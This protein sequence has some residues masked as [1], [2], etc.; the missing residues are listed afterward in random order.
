R[1]SKLLQQIA[2]FGLETNELDVA[3]KWI[4]AADSYANGLDP[5]IRH[6]FAEFAY[7]RSEQA[8]LIGE[9][10]QYLQQAIKICDEL[11]KNSRNSSPHPFHTILKCNLYNIEL[12]LEGNDDATV[13]RS[14]KEFDRRLAIAKQI[15]PYQDFILSAEAKFNQLFDNKPAALELME[16]AH[17]VNPSSPFIVSRL[18]ALLRETKQFDKIGRIIEK[19]LKNLPGDRELN[20]L[21]AEF[22][23]K[24]KP[25]DYD[26][27]SHH[28]NRSYTD[29][30]NR[31]Y[32]QYLHA[33]TLYLSGNKEAASGKFKKL[34]QLSIDPAIKNRVYDFVEVNGEKL[35]FT[36]VVKD[37]YYNHGWLLR[38]KLNDELF[39][40]SSGVDEIFKLTSNTR[41]KFS[42][43]FTYGGPI[44]FNIKVIN[45]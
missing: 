14:I 40:H 11:L 6:T 34:W 35:E 16:K 37:F 27:I 15:Y 43:G 19:S 12:A 10:R 32:A 28:L 42:L 41:V 38:D 33:K 39:F 5:Q 1:N 45:K 7:K 22:L 29:N 17:D 3:D 18:V 25:T 2:I 21:Y 44:A 20:L 24:T 23:I 31:H 26:L 8:R 9:K 4:K 36:G 13:E 30:D